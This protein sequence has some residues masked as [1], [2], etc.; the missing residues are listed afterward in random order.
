MTRFS[1]D[2]LREPRQELGL[3]GGIPK[4]QGRWWP[5]AGLVLLLLLAVGSFAY[6]E[7]LCSSGRS[8]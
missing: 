7:T 6:F 1:L 3:P 4:A 8:K 5:G 2:L